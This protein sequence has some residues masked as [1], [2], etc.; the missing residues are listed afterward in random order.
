MV[1]MIRIAAATA[2]LVSLSSIGQPPA[3]GAPPKGIQLSPLGVYQT[4]FFDEGALEI[5]AY[6]PISRR[7]FI[8]FAAQPRVGVVDLSNPA[9]PVAL[10]SIDLTPWGI[11]AH[12]TSVAV[13]NGVLAVAVPQGEDDVAMG[14]AVFFTTEGAL[15]RAVTVGALPDMITFTPDGQAVVTANEGQPNNAYTIDPEGS[16]SV[17]DVSAGVTTLTDDDVT[18][19]GFG[20]FNQGVLDPSIRIFGPGA[21]VAQD[22]EPEYIAISH[23]SKTAWVSLQENNAIAIVDLKQK[24]VTRLVGLGFKNHGE[25]GMGLDG[26]RDDGTIAIRRWPLRGMYQPDA[27][28]TFK[29]QSDTYLVS[30][31]EGDVR[32]YAGLNA[33]KPN[34][35]GDESVEIEDIRLDPTAFPNAA[36]LQD[37]VL[38][39]GRLKVTSFDGDTDGD[40]DFDEL[41]TF[42]A[43]SFSI[44]SSAGVLQFDSGDFL[45]QLTAAVIPAH[46]N[47]SSTNNTRDDRSDDKGPEPEGVT[48]A[49]LFGRSYLFVMLERIGGVAVFDLEIPTAPQFV[50]YI[51]TRNFAALPRTA[52]AGDLGPEAARVVP[53]ESS[54]TG[55]PLLIVSNEVSGSLRVFEIAPVK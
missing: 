18:T 5:A 4:G 29:H 12:A 37:R 39:I 55:V 23:D 8:T 11:N 54:P 41:Y 31:N 50:Q 34:A 22:L 53:A 49:K 16:I 43:R 35:T 46:F 15:L 48:V 40:G 19:I 7:A 51:N 14:K 36:T 27:L 38:G 1:T 2:V 20:Q 10:A 30:A 6:D 33:P 9:N 13:D 45:E 52:A 47:A 24:V 44:W 26:G 3:V 25:I 42:G 17:I 28:A 32:E 21:S